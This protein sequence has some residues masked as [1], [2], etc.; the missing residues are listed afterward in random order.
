[1][2][3]IY[4]FQQKYDKGLEMYSP[5]YFQTR[6]GGRRQDQCET[7]LPQRNLLHESVRVLAS[8]VGTP[9]SSGLGSFPKHRGGEAEV[10]DAGVVEAA[11]AKIKEPVPEVFQVI[12]A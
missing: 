4:I 3:Q 2:A 8:E 9:K 6:K 12:L 10:L 5:S 11:V 7:P 1:M